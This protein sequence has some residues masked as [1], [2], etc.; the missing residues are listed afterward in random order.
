MA[1]FLTPPTSPQRSPPRINI[2][3]DII[4]TSR[5]TQHCLFCNSIQHTIDVCN[6]D[7]LIVFLNYN[8]NLKY[9]FILS[10]LDGNTTLNNV[11]D[12]FNSI[13]ENWTES[14]IRAYCSKLMRLSSRNHLS[15][16][17][18][19]ILI[20][21]E[22]AL[23]AQ[24]TLNNL[25]ITNDLIERQLGLIPNDNIILFNMYQENEIIQPLP[26][27][28]TP[29][30]TPHI[31]YVQNPHIETISKDCPVCYECI[32]PKEQ[33]TFNCSHMMCGGCVGQMVTYS[34]NNNLNCPLCRTLISTI[35][36]IS[37]ECLTKIK[38]AE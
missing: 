21:D 14:Q 24:N 29:T 12:E 8:N 34:S 38:N 32:E 27:E 2:I 13:V 1:E 25:H 33:I 10:L 11:I 28:E 36:Y 22:F 3:R 18:C 19:K 30:T 5:Q 4:R 35:N 16:D 9:G 31:I 20:V 6:C 37:K 17:D 23:Y 15:I 7:E 26:I